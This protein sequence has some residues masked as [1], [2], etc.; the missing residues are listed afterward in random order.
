M[1]RG[2]KYG[3]NG[4]NTELHLS[5]AFRTSESL[6]F[7][8][9]SNI[10][11]LCLCSWFNWRCLLINAGRI[12][13]EDFGRIPQLGSSLGRHNIKAEAADH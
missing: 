8:L 13:K 3:A 5:A 11:I 7:L 4:H 10:Q 6:V 2:I 1:V 9:V 12:I